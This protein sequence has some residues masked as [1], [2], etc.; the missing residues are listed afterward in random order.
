MPCGHTRI[1]GSDPEW[2]RITAQ[3][4]ES[5]AH[6]INLFNGDN[7]SQ[8]RNKSML[9]EVLIIGGKQDEKTIYI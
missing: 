4:N 9:Q 8:K 2:I 6:R 1:A 5:E 3:T 7:K